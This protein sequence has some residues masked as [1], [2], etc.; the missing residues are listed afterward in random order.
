M[1][2]KNKP[3]STRTFN[4]VQVRTDKGVL[5]LQFLSLLVPT[6]K[7][8]GAN[9]SRYKSL[10]KREIDPHTGV[11]N[12]YWAEAIASRIQADIELPDSLFDYTLKKYLDVN[13]SDDIDCG[14]ATAFT[15]QLTVG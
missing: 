9:F 5:R 3:K 2:K 8:K 15:S 11:S 4:R 13:I 14:D 7:A 12:R 10:G 1:A 6:L